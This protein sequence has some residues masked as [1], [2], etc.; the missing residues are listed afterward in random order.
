MLRSLREVEIRC[1]YTKR[2]F[3]G[4]VYKTIR[5]NEL[6]DAYVRLSV[7]RGEGRFGISHKD[8][9]VPNVVIVAKR[10]EGYARWMHDKGIGVAVVRIRTNEHSPLSRMKSANF[11][12]YIIARYEAKS[13]NLDD[14][15]MLNTAGQVAEAATSNVFLV[16]R[17][18]VMTPCINSGI[19]P[20]VT[21]GE[22]ISIAGKTGLRVV[23]KKISP[24]ELYAADE[25]FLTNSLAEIIP[26]VKIDS[27]RIGSGVPGPIT[28][29]LHALYK[30]EVGIK[31][32]ERA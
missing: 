6:K 5:A 18:C 31:V 4:A 26:V 28:R 22:V 9:F 21:R 32:R 2:Y 16:K 8:R 14:A 17:K 12:N 27:K 29:R 24:R 15:I 10:F 7:T 1:P 25:V 13:R 20:G 23:E 3:K 11:M 30:K 19:L